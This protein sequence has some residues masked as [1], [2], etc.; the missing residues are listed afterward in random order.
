MVRHPQVVLDP[1]ICLGKPIVEEVGIATGILDA[2]FRA[3][4]NDAGIVADWYGV[5]ERR[6]LAAVEFSEA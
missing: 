6:V 5:Q 4:H 3:N 1:L 2:A